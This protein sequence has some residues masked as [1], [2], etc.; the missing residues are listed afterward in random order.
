MERDLDGV[1]R[2]L[3]REIAAS[4]IDATIAAEK[5]ALRRCWRRM[6]MRLVRR[7]EWE[8]V[9]ALRGKSVA[10]LEAMLRER[11]VREIDR[12]RV[13]GEECTRRVT[14]VATTPPASSAEAAGRLGN[15]EKTPGIGTPSR[16]PGR[17]GRTARRWRRN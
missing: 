6:R 4:G 11:G 16:P 8:A 1:A 10:E 5:A 17:R 2:R 7:G 3:E 9:R 12:A 15:G 14:D 13:R